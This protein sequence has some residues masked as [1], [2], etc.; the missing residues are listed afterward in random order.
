MLQAFNDRI[1]NS[2]WLGYAIVIAISIPFAL[3]G[4]QAYVGGPDES[5]AAEVNGTE[6]MASVLD[7][8][9]SQQR[10]ELRE[11][12][13][14]LPSEF[15]DSLL[16]RQALE[17]LITRELLKQAAADAY[18]RVNDTRLARR[19][20]QQSYFRTDG[21]FDR[22]L[23]ERTLQQAGMSPSQYEAQAREE[24]V[25]EQLR[26]GVGDT[27]FVLED[28]SRRLARLL[29]QERRVGVLRRDR[30]DLEA[31]LEIDADELRS[32]YRDHTDDFQRPARV[33]VAYIELDLDAL[34]R[35]VEV[36]EED[37]RA[38][39]RADQER[40]REQAEREAAHI[41]IEVP[42]D[43]SDDALEQARAQAERLRERI[44]EGADFAA[45]AREHSDDAGSAAQGGELGY[46]TRDT[47]GQVFDEALFSLD[48]PGTVS[49]PVQSRYG[50]HLIKLLDVR[51]PESKSLDE[52]RDEIEQD[53]RT[54][55]AERLF[56][57]RV[58]V[59]R[60][61]TYENPGALEP[62]ADATGLEVQRSDWFSRADGEGIAA[63]EA[64]REAAFGEEVLDE[65]RNSDLI[66]LGRRHVAVL[67]TIDHRPP[68]PRPF[69]EVRDTVEERVR[70]Q[71]V[72]ERLRAWS[73]EVVTGLEEGK[74]PS[75]LARDGS[76]HRDLGWI[77]E[78]DG[79]V[80]A[81]IR[82]A[83]FELAP[84]EEEDV[85]YRAVELDDGDRAVV[86]VSGV[87]LPEVGER[88][89]RTARERLQGAIVGGE[90]GAWV[91]ALRE[92]ADIERNERVLER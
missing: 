29:A 24:Y 3:W 56:Y 13:G 31:Q 36:S 52:V 35:Q 4:I 48:E 89:V 30:A 67:R 38:Q 54:R 50:F 45:L 46:L 53:L 86:I 5:V 28:E 81:A 42:G 14:E 92:Q 44:A 11:R 57:D 79:E 70:A 7:Q 62:A 60:N 69:E 80:P 90:L 17:S 2:R 71:R 58:E 85:T 68:E 63:T 59:L 19:I 27:G 34:G 6:I 82:S 40:Y 12:F 73:E 9:V 75:A 23:Y 91:A 83:A 21:R 77:S 43:A 49:E 18:F 1:R 74:E 25:V 78:A 10:R 55:R 65:G 88:E 20:Q 39:Y 84:P 22:G 61:S 26:Q 32:Y 51:E 8:R 16:R 47:M 72:A 37:V 33:R 76:E 15:S 87:R 64:V 66:E 41:L